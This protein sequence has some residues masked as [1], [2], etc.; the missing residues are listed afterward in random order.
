MTCG[1]FVRQNDT[2]THKTAV[3]NHLSET[4]AC[5]FRISA[6]KV[7]V[8]QLVFSARNCL[9]IA[10]RGLCCSFHQFRRCPGV[11]KHGHQWY[12]DIDPIAL[13]TPRINSPCIV[14]EMM[15]LDGRHLKNGLNMNHYST[16]DR[17]LCSVQLRRIV[18]FVTYW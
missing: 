13:R 9:V 11:L 1:T 14:P 5:A 3:I 2:I 17:I 18:L 4:L 12:F 8:K 15:R 16:M 6:R 7:S 10:R